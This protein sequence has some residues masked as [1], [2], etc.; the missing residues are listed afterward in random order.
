M[1]F[2]SAKKEMEIFIKQYGYN[3]EETTTN[4]LI[5]GR[6]TQVHR[7][8]YIVICEYSECRAVTKGSFFRNAQIPS[9]FPCV[10]DFVLLKHNPSGVSQIA[11]VLPRHSKFNRAN[12][13][14]K[15]A[16]YVKNISEQM[17]AANFDYVF[18]VT[19]LNQ[20]FNVE[21]ILRYLT[22][23]R[24]SGAKPVIILTKAD[25]N[26]DYMDMVDKMTQSAPNVPIHAVSS[27][28]GFGME[29][30]DEYLQPAKTIVFLGMS[31]VGKSSLLNVLMDE[32]VMDVSSI[33]ENDSKGRHTTT[34]RQLFMLPSGAMVI[35]T[36]G[37][38]ELGLYGA[39]DG[40]EAEFEDIQDLF[41]QCRFRSCKH[42]TEPDCAVLA[43]IENGTLSEKR[44]KRYIAQNKELKFVE[45]KAAYMAA[46]KEDGKAQGKFRKELKKSG[47]K[48]KR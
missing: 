44:W 38:R 45:D 13:L 48:N 31:G 15:G 8:Q 2:F 35:D 33:R 47:G 10:G 46:Q 42:Q 27:H 28:T 39:D 40:L 16:G 25:L 24:Q 29:G 41:N 1:P 6:V 3:G 11:E 23:A 26:P 18:M 9:D 12:F 30:L 7:S 14:G 36:P 4:G 20:D 37:M 21:R 22:Q 17:V 5:I 19:S 43:A 34:H 32:D